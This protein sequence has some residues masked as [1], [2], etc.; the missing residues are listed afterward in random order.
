MLRTIVL[1][2]DDGDGVTVEDYGGKIVRKDNNNV[3]GSK[4][5]MNQ[6]LEME[7]SI[8]ELGLDEFPA[9]ALMMLCHLDT[10]CDLQLRRITRSHRYHWWR[11]GNADS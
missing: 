9:Y 2:D 11:E 3:G 10:M 7:C 6:V 8:L 5:E 1:P 4:Q